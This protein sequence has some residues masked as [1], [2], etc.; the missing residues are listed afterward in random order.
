[1]NPLALQNYLVVG[2]ILFTLGAIGFLTAAQ[3]YHP[4][5]SAEMMLQGVA[6]NLVAIRPPP[7]QRARA[8]LYLVHHHCRGV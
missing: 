5:L 2:A 7:R 8:S 1:M 3:P 4:V 6:I